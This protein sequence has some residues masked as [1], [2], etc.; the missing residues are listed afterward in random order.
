MSRDMKVFVP[1]AR[2]KE[3]EYRNVI[4]GNGWAWVR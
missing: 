1:S 3:D 2:I 4:S